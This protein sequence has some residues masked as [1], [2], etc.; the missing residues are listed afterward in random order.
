MDPIVI[1]RHWIVAQAT[2]AGVKSACCLPYQLSKDLPDVPRGDTND[3][4]KVCCLKT[5][6]LPQVPMCAGNTKIRMFCL[7]PS[8]MY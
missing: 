7:G 5:M 6:N 8:H 3:G 1:D 4:R 2:T